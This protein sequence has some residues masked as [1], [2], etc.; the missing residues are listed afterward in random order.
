M[1]ACSWDYRV[2]LFVPTYQ[3]GGT[4]SLKKARMLGDTKVQ[5]PSPLDRSVISRTKKSTLEQN[6]RS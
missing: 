3:N 5:C 2:E 4:Q 6:A 1:E